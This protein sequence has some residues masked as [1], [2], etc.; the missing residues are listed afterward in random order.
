MIICPVCKT[1]HPLNLKKA[2]SILLMACPRCRSL[3]LHCHGVTFSVNRGGVEDLSRGGH[4]KS[5]QKLLEAIARKK[6]APRTP[7]VHLFIPEKVKPGR[8]KADAPGASRERAISG[9]D[10]LDLVIDLE[11]TDSVT[12][13]LERLDRLDPKVGC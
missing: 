5:G 13:F 1:R 8:K 6:K 7:Q 12:G 9:Q 11:T 10:V 2:R 4:I 3:L